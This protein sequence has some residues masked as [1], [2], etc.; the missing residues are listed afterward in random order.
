[1]AAEKEI[2]KLLKGIF[3]KFDLL[4]DNQPAKSEKLIIFNNEQ[5]FKE[6][7]NL[8]MLKNDLSFE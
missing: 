1:L 5:L 8:A 2:S 3:D 6:N 4:G 7:P